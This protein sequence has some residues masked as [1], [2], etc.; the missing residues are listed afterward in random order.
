MKDFKFIPHILGLLLLM[1]C[2]TWTNIGTAQTTD[3]INYLSPRQ[4]KK[5]GQK[6]RKMEDKYTAIKYYERY[7]ELDST[8]YDVR[9]TLANLYHQTRNYTKAKQAFKQIYQ[10]R[11]EEYIVALYK[12]A[13]TLKNHGEYQKAK[14]KLK[15]F[16]DE[17]SGYDYSRRDLNDEIESL[18][19]AIEQTQNPINVD[20][21]HLNNSINRPH[22]EFSPLLLNNQTLLYASL[23]SDT[24]PTISTQKTNPERPHRKFYTAKRTGEN[25]EYQGPFKPFNDPDTNTGNGALSP[26]GKTFYFTKCTKN[27]EHETICHIYYSK[28]KDGE[29][30]SPK[31]M[32][33]PVNINGYSSTQPTMGTIEKFR[34]TQPIL[35]FVSDRPSRSQGG[36]DIWYS[37]FDV[38][39]SAFSRVRNAGGR[40]INTSGN[41]I[42]PYYDETSNMLYYSSDHQSPYGGYDI[43]KIQGNGRRWN[44]KE[45]LPYPVNTGSDELYFYRNQQQKEEAFFTSNRKG[46]EELLYPTCCDDIYSVIFKDYITIAFKGTIYEV[47]PRANYIKKDTA[48]KEPLNNAKAEVY[49]FNQQGDSNMNYLFSDETDS[50]GNYF[51]SLDPNQTYRLLLKKDG[52]FYEMIDVNTQ[53]KERSDTIQKDA[54]LI[55]IPEEPIVFNIH[56]KFDSSSLTPAAKEKIDT[57][58]YT[59]LKETPDI[60]VRLTSHTDSVGSKQ[61]NKE[62]SQERAQSVVEY[63]K[64]KGIDK[65]RLVAKGLGETQPIATNKTE[66]GRAK[67][68]R[69]EFKVVGS[70]NPYS[71]LNVNKMKIIKKKE[72]GKEIRKRRRN[73]NQ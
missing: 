22:I 67:N 7:K 6:A 25:W 11:P 46:S 66:E 59:I 69:T 5:F 16:K 34:K 56:Y 73:K 39:D 70:T 44:K 8:N 38:R 18:N 40:Y 50:T 28:K 62:L 3:R 36:W 42:T 26:N 4:L 58:I 68:R 47:P 52:Y 9:M 20:I 72:K 2:N 37:I 19:K 27:W 53:Q 64:Q 17:Y 23:R 57:T 10:Q 14:E 55:K 65:K 12:Y 35:Y 51:V 60:I 63:L 43:Y 41:E 32:N 24:L 21:T 30:Q 1:L 71:Q 33:A 61:Y 15:Q 29:W 45:P 13:Q 48:Q 31:K 54:Y 49:Y